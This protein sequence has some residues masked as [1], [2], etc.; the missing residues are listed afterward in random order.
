MHT[1]MRITSI[2]IASCFLATSAIAKC[3][4]HKSN[5]SQRY[6]IK[7]GEVFDRKTNLVW[8]RCSVGLRWTG[9]NCQGATKPLSQ[10][11]A[12][13][14]AE[15]MGPAWRIPS[16][17]ELS[18]L[19]DSS[20][21]SPMIDKRAFPDIHSDSEEPAAYWTASSVNIEGMSDYFYFVDF[22]S[23]SVDFHSRGFELRARLVRS[24]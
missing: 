17:Q 22:I 6:E 3:L 15:I 9:K 11:E 13:K 2:M 21:D 20:C 10:S 24:R 7:G 1:K 16:V 14:T 8:Q 4:D 18:S 19:I 12:A 5:I 23:G